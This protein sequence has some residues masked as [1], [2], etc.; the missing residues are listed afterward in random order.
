MAVNCFLFNVRG[1][2]GADKSAGETAVKQLEYILVLTACQA[3]L[4]ILITL[5]LKRTSHRVLHKLEDRWVGADLSDVPKR[6]LIAVKAREA[7]L[8]CERELRKA[9]VCLDFS[10]FKTTWW[11]ILDFISM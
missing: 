2:P 5:L 9:E 3:P 4:L 10:L 11:Y 6:V 1:D 8:L 7:V